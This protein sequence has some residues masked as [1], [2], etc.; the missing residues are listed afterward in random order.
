MFLSIV[1][2][3]F[4]GKLLFIKVCVIYF[5]WVYGKLI[6]YK[7]FNFTNLSNTKSD[8]Y[9]LT[10]SDNISSDID[11]GSIVVLSAQ[12]LFW[13]SIGG[14]ILNVSY[15]DFAKTLKL[16]FPRGSIFQ[17]GQVQ[18]RCTYIKNLD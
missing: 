3:Y 6:K 9:Y 15:D 1:K 10:L 11:D 4:Y 8:I 16:L 12:I 14:E 18:V 13:T 17:K 5:L 2:M 7:D